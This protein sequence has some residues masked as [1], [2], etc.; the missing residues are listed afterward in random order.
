MGGC[1]HAVGGR[2]GSWEGRDLSGG[3]QGGSFK[4]RDHCGRDQDGSWKGDRCGGDRDNTWYSQGRNK[5]GRNLSS[6]GWGH[7]RGSRRHDQGGQAAAGAAGVATWAA[8]RAR[9]GSRYLLVRCT[10][11]A[12]SKSAP[13]QLG[14]GVV[15]G[16]VGFQLGSSEREAGGGVNTLYLTSFTKIA[17]PPH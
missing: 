11:L 3:D 14:G 12:N 10:M 5:G 16:V 9:L 4:G 7:S 2:F 15:G 8:A 13:P 17:R 1:V 6:G